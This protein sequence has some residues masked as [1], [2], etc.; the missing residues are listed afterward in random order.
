MLLNVNVDEIDVALI[1]EEQDA[2]LSFTALKDLE[3]RGKVTRIDP[4][5]T[6]VSGAVA[7]G[8]EI[9]F[10]PGEVPVRLGMTADVDIVVAEAEDVLLVPNRVIDADREAGRYFVNMPGP[11]ESSE[12]VEVQIGLR[13]RTHTEIVAG[14]EAGDELLLPQVPGQS[15][16]QAGT[17][18][19]MQ[20]PQGGGLFGGGR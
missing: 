3:V 11:A 19:P 16:E 12:R 14:L 4:S 18:M 17:G 1:A 15:E 5:S 10:D 7:F 20:G 9:G 6:L 13:D 8:V 2:Y